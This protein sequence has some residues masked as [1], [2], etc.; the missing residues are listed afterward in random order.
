MFRVQNFWLIPQRGVFGSTGPD[1]EGPLSTNHGVDHHTIAPVVASLA[2]HTT[3]QSWQVWREYVDIFGSLVLEFMALI[4]LSYNPGHYGIVMTCTGS[5]SADKKSAGN[6]KDSEPT[7][8]VCVFFPFDHFWDSQFYHVSSVEMNVSV[9][10]SPHLVTLATS[11]RAWSHTPTSTWPWKA[12]TGRKLLTN[13]N[14]RWL[15]QQPIWLLFCA[16]KKM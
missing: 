11:T 4:Q 2:E 13:V 15:D 14:F 6:D 5:S 12:K 16:H 8:W 10:D 9:A 7:C 3:C 1:G